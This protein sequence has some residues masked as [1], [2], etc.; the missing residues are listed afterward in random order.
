M[1]SRK[2]Q[3]LERQ[4]RRLR[5]PRLQLLVGGASLPLHVED[6]PAARGGRDATVRRPAAVPQHLVFDAVGGANTAQPHRARVP[7]TRGREVGMDDVAEVAEQVFI[8]RGSNVNWYL[9]RDGMDLTLVDAGYPGDLDWV[10]ESV[11]SLGPRPEDI[12]AILLTHAHV[13]HMGA[14]NALHDRSGM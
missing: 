14:S 8:V 2:R 7:A 3:G 4:Q 5:R 9:L 10:E 11:R 13:D 12:G 6:R 1:K